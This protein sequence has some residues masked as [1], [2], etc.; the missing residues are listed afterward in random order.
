MQMARAAVGI[1]SVAGFAV[2]PGFLL[3][4]D[5]AYQSSVERLT[6][7]EFVD[8]VG[9]YTL[10]AETYRAQHWP[11][12]ERA[13]LDSA[14]TILESQVQAQPDEA[15]FHSQLGVVYAD[16]G[17]KADAVREG[18]AAVRLL[19]VSKEAYRGV[20]LQ[21]ALA[22]IYATVGKRAEAIERLKYLLSIPSLISPATLRVDPRWAPLRGDPGFERLVGRN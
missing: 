4:A 1:S 7:P 15:S 19:P 16:L 10:K 11:R 5:P 17:R 18:E 14:R 8:S 2:S 13:Y 20:N 12:L 22:Q 21:A 3:A 6:L 9:Y